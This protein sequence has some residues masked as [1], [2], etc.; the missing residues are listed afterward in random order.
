MI[1]LMR[2][3]KVIL[4]SKGSFRYRFPGLYLCDPKYSQEN[5]VKCI[6]SSVYSNVLFIWHLGM[7]YDTLSSL[8]TI[9]LT[10]LKL[11]FFFLFSYS[12]KI[13]DC[14]GLLL[15]PNVKSGS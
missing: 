8:K 10:Y 15:I 5:I 1:F 2:S 7:L 6:Q 9:K 4:N 11:C 12:K 14:L 3:I 13:L